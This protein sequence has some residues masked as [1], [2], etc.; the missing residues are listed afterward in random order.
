MSSHRRKDTSCKQTLFY[1]PTFSTQ[2]NFVLL[3]EQ[4]LFFL[5]IR[6]NAPHIE[7]SI[8]LLIQYEF[9]VLKMSFAFFSYRKRWQRRYAIKQ[10]HMDKGVYILAVSEPREKS[11]ASKHSKQR[12]IFQDKLYEWF[13]WHN[14]EGPLTYQTSSDG[15]IVPSQRIYFTVI[16]IVDAII[17]QVC[18]GL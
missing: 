14:W 8:H 13:C 7:T 15:G 10:N 4:Q 11:S 6:N 9:D 12:T 1:C 5:T 18:V 16:T 3:L 17:I 2:G